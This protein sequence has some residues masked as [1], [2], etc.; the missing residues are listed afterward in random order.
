MYKYAL[1][2]AEPYIVETEMLKNRTY[3]SYRWKQ[4]AISNDLEELKKRLKEYRRI[5]NW[6]TLE[7][8]LKHP[9]QYR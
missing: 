5:I 3:Q 2:Y 6:E 4:L 7:V 1:E 9:R 8:I